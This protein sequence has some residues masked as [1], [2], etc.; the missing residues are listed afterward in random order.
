MTK[1][2]NIINSLVLAGVLTCTPLFVC[3]SQSIVPSEYPKV[4]N[5]KLEELALVETAYRKCIDAAE[6]MDNPGQQE[7]EEGKCDKIRNDRE[8][9]ID[10]TY[11]PLLEE[12]QAKDNAKKTETANKSQSTSEQKAAP[13]EQSS[14][15]TQKSEAKP[16]D[17][18][19]AEREAKEKA[20]KDVNQM[21]AAMNTA[22]ENR[23]K[24]VQNVRNEYDAK[25]E[26]TKNASCASG[27]TREAC[28][29][30]KAVE[31]SKLEKEKEAKASEKHKELSGAVETAE[32]DLD[33]AKK[34]QRLYSGHSGIEHARPLLQL[35]GQ[36]TRDPTSMVVMFRGN[37]LFK[38]WIYNFIFFI[39]VIIIYRLIL[40]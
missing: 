29:A 24:E 17:P 38:Y 39:Y 31:V 37:S 13:K 5:R 8:K 40:F 28:Q 1:I 33:K 7:E 18:L 15:S 16:V 36:Y 14:S 26:A 35:G 27:E 20:E 34:D 3:F 23:A 22:A 2:K 11:V 32:N 10:E 12:A 4:F 19:K 30:R 9:A 21:A 6:D 25:I